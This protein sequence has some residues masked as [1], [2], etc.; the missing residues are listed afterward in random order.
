MKSSMKSSLHWIRMVMVKLMDRNSAESLKILITN[1]LPTLVARSKNPLKNLI[2]T[3]KS[4]IEM[5]PS[6]NSPTMLFLGEKNSLIS[7]AETIVIFLI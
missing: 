2:G 5:M 6:I 1:K 7:Q 4:T 3:K